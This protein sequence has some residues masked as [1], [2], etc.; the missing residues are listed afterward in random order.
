MMFQDEQVLCECSY[1]S[2]FGFGKQRDS[3]KRRMPCEVDAE[4]SLTSYAVDALRV[5]ADRSEHVFD[6]NILKG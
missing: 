5:I 6:G 3:E 4:M 2:F 1:H